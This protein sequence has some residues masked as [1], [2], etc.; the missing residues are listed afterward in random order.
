MPRG[1]QV[2]R[3]RHAPKVQASNGWEDVSDVAAAYGL[4][5]DPWQENVL[6][7][8]M[9]ERTDGR[10]STPRVGLA[11]PRQ[12]G[13]G[14][15]MEARELAGLLVFGEQMIIHS[16]HDQ[17][18]ARIGFDRVSSYFENFDDLRKRVK[19][20]GSA[21]NREYIELKT[22][23]VLRFLA[24][25]RS[26]GRGFSAD[27]LFLDEA[28]EL[29]D[30]AWAAILPTTSARFNPQVWLLGTP[31]SPEMNGEV[32][33]R[34]RD[35]GVE[36]KDHR[37]CWCEWSAEPDADLD[38]V[39]VWAATNPSLGADR[40]TGVTVESI[41]GERVALSDDGFGRE[42]LGIWETVSTTHVIDPVKWAA[43]KDIAS[44]V[45]LPVAVAIDVSPMGRSASISL[46]GRRADGLYHAEHIKHAKGTDWILGDLRTLRDTFP[47]CTFVADKIGSASVLLQLAEHDFLIAQTNATQMAQ[48]CAGLLDAVDNNVIRHLDQPLLNSAIGSSRK[49]VIGD[50]WAWNR[51]D[52]NNDITP[53]VSVTLALWGFQQGVAAPKPKPSMSYAF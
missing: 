19:Q 29:S 9:G 34:L 40:E 45:E 5:L 51:K 27:C 33:T 53:L 3:V 25:S 16:A 18:T 37:L 20:V 11:V 42:R 2:P 24:R 38:D 22:G 41:A 12:S 8:A 46:A 13:K 15:I 39:N 21:L 6:Q 14:A 31:P 1:V 30:D 35:A 47:G 49:R 48:A 28:Q 4:K 32:F 26:S 44:K 52:S 10:W 17:K 23:Q 36:G 50:G 43:L 7:A